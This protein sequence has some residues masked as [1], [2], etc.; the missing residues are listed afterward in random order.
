MSP[1]AGA[2][3]GAGP[4]APAS[5]ARDQLPHRDGEEDQPAPYAAPRVHR[6]A[7]ST[8]RG[9]APPGP[10]RWPRWAPSEWR[11]GPGAVVPAEAGPRRPAGATRCSRPWH[12]SGG[13][14]PGGPG[15]VRASEAARRGGGP[16]P[17]AGGGGGGTRGRPGAAAGAGRGSR[18]GRARGRTRV[19]FRSRAVTARSRTGPE[20]SRGPAPDSAGRTAPGHRATACPSR[21]RTARHSLLRAHRAGKREVR[22]GQGE[23]S[24]PLHARPAPAG[25]G[26][27]R[28]SPDGTLTLTPLR[29]SSA[30]PQWVVAA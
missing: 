13:R 22:C 3:P 15:G 28:R 2:G 14:A 18:T 30:A 7:V 19:P 21:V 1:E 5:A 10:W 9:A 23:R 29:R 8:Q 25:S 16:C 17:P 11:P 27:R 6:R 26:G 24:F 4:Q 12:G 20:R